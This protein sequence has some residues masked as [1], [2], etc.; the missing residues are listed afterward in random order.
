MK[1]TYIY[2]IRG[3]EHEWAIN[4]ELKPE[5]AA[6]MIADGIELGKLYYSLPD[7]IVSAGLSRVWMFATDIFHLRNPFVA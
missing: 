1:R 2:V 6:E 4:I 7:W 3:R 5:H